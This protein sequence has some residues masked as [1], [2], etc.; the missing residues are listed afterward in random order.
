MERNPLVEPA[1]SQAM[2]VVRYASPD[3]AKV[4][5]GAL[6]AEMD[7]ISSITDAEHRMLAQ[8]AEA[9]D[10]LED[11]FSSRRRDRTPRPAFYPV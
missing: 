1:L 5:S 7:P 10:G 2:R 6:W 9:V 3:T 11:L 8:N 4:S